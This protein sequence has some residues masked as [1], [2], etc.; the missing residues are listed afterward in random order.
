MFFLVNGIICFVLVFCAP[1]VGQ[2]T[3]RTEGKGLVFSREEPKS[4]IV[5][6]AE[7]LPLR[8][9]CPHVYPRPQ[10]S[11]GVGRG[12]L[13]ASLRHQAE[14]LQ[15][16]PRTEHREGEVAGIP[17]DEEGWAHFSILFVQAM[18]WLSLFYFN[19]TPAC[20]HN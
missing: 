10:L 6:C 19:A 8:G 14:R 16:L 4:N 3:K 15:G 17:Q 20:S 11:S 2:S 1:P 7:H 12:P 9:L 18:T 13:P 5:R